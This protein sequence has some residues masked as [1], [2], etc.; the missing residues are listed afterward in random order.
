MKSVGKMLS[1]CALILTVVGC[2]GAEE[3]QNIYILNK[4]KSTIRG[5]V[6]PTTIGGTVMNKNSQTVQAMSQAMAP[7]ACRIIN[8]TKP[9]NLKATQYHRLIFA[10][11]VLDGKGDVVFTAD[12]LIRAK[13]NNDVD[14]GVYSTII[15]QFS[16][17]K[18]LYYEI[19]DGVTTI[20][21]KPNLK[22]KKASPFPCGQA[23]EEIGNFWGNV[24][25]IGGSAKRKLKKASEAIAKAWNEGAAEE[26][27]D[28]PTPL[29]KTR[30][31]NPTVEE[32]RA[33]QAARTTAS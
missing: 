11:N 14:N 25:E 4:S 13:V 23:R 20:T 19:H 1:A 7:G 15:K 8:I 33:R 10:K 3:S 24:Q 5:G 16:K 27:M 26:E 17:G 29:P 18:D 9:A 6:Y 30:K 12:D 31:N 28:V 22:F 2:H 32:I 21:R